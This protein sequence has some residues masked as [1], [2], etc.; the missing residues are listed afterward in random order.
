MN[1]YRY[2]THQTP[3]LDLYLPAA[4]NLNQV[5]LARYKK[6]AEKMP[7]IK[8]FTCNSYKELSILANLKIK[9]INICDFNAV[10]KYGPADTSFLQHTLPSVE[11]IELDCR[12]GGYTH[13]A[14]YLDKILPIFTNITKIT[15]L[16]F[17]KVAW[18][19]FYKWFLNT[20]Y[21]N[22]NFYI[23][24]RVPQEWELL[25]DI[26]IQKI[27]LVENYQIALHLQKK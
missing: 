25:P 27:V 14:D 23:Y 22:E 19:K 26:N 18:D 5:I 11:S 9:H 1:T 16:N 3:A 7:N 15:L 4:P 6:I 21:F 8:Y 13:L 17:K 24:L 12:R 10:K 2:M 20:D